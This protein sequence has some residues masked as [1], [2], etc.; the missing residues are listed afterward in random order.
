MMARTLARRLAARVRHAALGVALVLAVPAAAGPGVTLRLP[1]EVTVQGPELTLGDLA[2]IEGDPALARR[3]QRV[4]LG[5]APLPGGSL[6][7]DP[8][9]LVLRLRQAQIDPAAVRVAAPDRVTVVRA[10]QPLSGETVLET[11]RQA[12]LARLQAVDPAGGPWAL[13]PIG[14]PADVR[15]PTGTL[16]LLAEVHDGPP[17]RLVVPVTVTVRVDDQDV[18]TLALAFRVVR[19][20]PVLVAARALEPRSTLGPEDFR[21][22]ER[23]ETELPPGALHAAVGVEDL[24]VTRALR[25]GDV[26]TDRVLRPRI[27]VRRGEAVTLVVEGPGFRITARG[28]M[29]EDGRRGDLVRVTNATSKREVSG[30][31]EAAGLVRVTP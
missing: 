17:P 23:P 11:A 14:R 25:P 27:L 12:A 22:E 9:H 16:A 29:A 24:E 31:V 28:V 18:R 21:V 8:D 10:F 2:R 26:V 7:L 6:R 5:A 15:L 1:A 13:V 20:Q 30:R 4:S 19:R 3:V